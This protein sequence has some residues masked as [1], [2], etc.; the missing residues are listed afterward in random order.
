MP[1]QGIRMKKIFCAIALA[2]M[3][4]FGTAHARAQSYGLYQTCQLQNPMGQA[5]AGAQV[6]FLTQPANTQS[7][8]PLAQ[9]YSSS[10]GGAVSQPISTNGFGSC[11]AYLSPGVYTVCYVSQYTGTSWLA[12]QNIIVGGGY[13]PLSGGSL[14]G[15]LTVPSLID[16][17]LGSGT[18]AVCPNG[19]GGAL[20]TSGCASGTD[21]NAVHINNSSTQTL[22]GPLGFGPA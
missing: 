14:S 12:D 5:I 21:S 13:L 7:L 17:S 2:A 8:T 6:Y 1:T 16:S 10:T 9:V 18:S 4:L 19:V 22:I 3:S 11:T 20:T 15:S